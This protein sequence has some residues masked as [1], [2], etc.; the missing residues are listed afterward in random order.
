MTKRFVILST[1]IALVVFPIAGLRMWLGG[2]YDPAQSTYLDME[3]PNGLV[4]TIVNERAG[5]STTFLKKAAETGG[6][7]T[8]LEI[9]LAPGGGNDPHYHQEFSEKFK[10]VSGTLGLKQ[11]GEEVLLEP[12]ET[13]LAEVGDEHAF[14]NPGDEPITFRV[15]IEPG[16]PGFEKALYILYGLTN[17][18]LVDEEGLPESIYHTA[19]FAALSDTRSHEIG[20]ALSWLIVRLA[21]RAQRLGIE[22]ELIETYYLSQVEETTDDP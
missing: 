4:R 21:G 5:H 20:A 2:P 1:L 6:E 14:Y 17:E 16:S 13:A 11:K 9:V 12:G 7:Y 3:P 15:R 22:D 8:L 18:G 19:V 10:A